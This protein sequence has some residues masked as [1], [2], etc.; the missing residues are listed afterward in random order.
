MSETTR[1][2][3]AS[4]ARMPGS[5]IGQLLAMR[6]A[7]APFNTA[8]GLRTVL[9]Y[10]GGWF[11]QWHEGP[12]QAVERTWEISRSHATHS[13]PRVVHRSVGAGVLRESVQIAALVGPDRATDVARKV[14]ELEREQQ[15]APL[16]PA[17]IWRRFG[18]PPPGRQ[19]ACDWSRHRSLA[20]VGEYTQA[21]DLVRALAERNGAP[22][23]Y[24]RYAG[25]DLRHAD[26]GAAYVDV[27]F[28]GRCT[29]VQALSRHVLDYS[30]AR[31]A[32]ERIDGVVLLTSG[33]K[34][35][36]TPLQEALAPFMAS[37]ERPASFHVAGPDSRSHL[38]A[39]LDVIAR[40]HAM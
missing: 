15:Q 16:E 5:V 39:V 32:F 29:R 27:P 18:A 24:Q 11:V 2:I 9:L 20:V 10:T 26:A 35:G 38:Q 21:I 14:F 31:L 33:R 22:M 17:H 12:E 1:F 19:V 6:R 40:V 3:A 13:H 8:R 28:A 36:T 34:A 25:P 37:I 7:I 4:I 23:N 30:I